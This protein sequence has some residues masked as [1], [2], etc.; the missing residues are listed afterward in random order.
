MKVTEVPCQTSDEI[1]EKT[2]STMCEEGRI[3]EYTSAANPAMKEIPVMFHPAE[4]HRSGPTRVIPFD[5]SKNIGVPYPCS[6][7]NLMASFLR[8]CKGEQLGTSARATSQAFYVIAGKGS[9]R[10]DMH[11]EIPWAM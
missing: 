3:Y 5:L 8:I 4:Q 7:P 2:E 9:S 11:G 1:N 6:S 10:S